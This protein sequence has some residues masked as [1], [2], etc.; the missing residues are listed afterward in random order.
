MTINFNEIGKGE[1]PLNEINA[2]LPRKVRLY[3]DDAHKLSWCVVIFLAVGA[4]WFCGY[5]PNIA[6]QTR[7]WAVLQRDGREAVGEIRE[8]TRS[9]HATFIR[10]VF[11]VDNEAYQNTVELPS[12]RHIDL[13]VGDKILV[14]FLPSDPTVN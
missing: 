10:Y 6:K 1:A 8:R 12:G 11:R 5:F 4:V 9:I 13:S 2:A 7:Q 14:R 3:S